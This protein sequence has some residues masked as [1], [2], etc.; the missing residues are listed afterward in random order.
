MP[1][2]STDK[3]IAAAVLRRDRAERQRALISATVDSELPIAA[4]VTGVIFFLFGIADGIMHPAEAGWRVASSEIPA[5]I[6]MVCAMCAWRRLVPVRW[7]SWTYGAMVV[8]SITSTI[9]TVAIGKRAEELVFTLLILAAAGAAVPSYPVYV[10]VVGLTAVGYWTTLASLHLKGDGFGHWF[11]AGAVATA[12][13]VYVLTSRRRSIAALVDAERNIENMA[14]NDSLTGVYNRNGLRML[15]VEMM[16]LAGRQQV[17]VFAV[18]VDVDGLKAVN[19]TAG[20]EAGDMVL[21][22]V[23]AQ[24]DQSFRKGDLVARWGGDEFV[25]LGIGKRLD[26]DVVEARVCAA[27]QVHPDRPAAWTPSLSAG[28]A[29]ASEGDS[30]FGDVDTLIDDADQE[31]Y[32]RRGDRRRR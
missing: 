2:D 22:L 15:G 18:F 23:A 6:L 21:R 13:S 25:V 29:M 14:V 24:L 4:T 9:L 1:S 7:V 12:A 20:H 19:D 31:M 8:V 5:L 28:F 11:N 3:V 16:A 10:M 30:A 32:R 27:L 26:P 17:S